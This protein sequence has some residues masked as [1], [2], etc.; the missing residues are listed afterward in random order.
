MS[1]L[2]DSS[3]V[4]WPTPMS[5]FGQNRFGEN[6]YRVV[7]APERRHIVYGEWPDGG[8]R[9][10][11]APAYPHAG[12]NWVLER[13]ME[14]FEYT[15][16]TAEVWNMTMTMLGP[17]PDRG[18]YDLVHVF[19]PVQPDDISIEE[20]IRHIEA[21]RKFFSQA[22]N[23]QACKANYEK[24][25][26]DLDSQKDAMIRNSFSAFGNA[27]MAGYGGGRGTKTAPILKT[28]EEVNLPTRHLGS[29]VKQGKQMYKVM[30][31]V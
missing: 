22:E 26:A 30:L 7:W 2:I 19:D 13:W 5:R 20:L 11:W 25:K 12:K 23:Y 3:L 4:F 16:C 31:P 18:E 1:A 27:P 29:R 9:A 21:G 14:P 28:A 15:G 10:E 6:L 24:Q 8:K 17:Y